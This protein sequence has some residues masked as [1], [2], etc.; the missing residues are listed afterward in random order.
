MALYLEYSTRI[1]EVYLKYI[2]PED[3]HVYSIDEVFMDVTNYLQTYKLTPHDLAM[4]I[5]L[6]VLDTTGITATAGI[7]TNL[8]LCKVAMDIV[9]KHIP[10]DENGVRIAELDEMAYRR[11][12]WEH[13]P[14]TDFWR[15]G[16]GYAKKLEEH[17]MFTM[18]DIARCSIGGEYDYHNEDLLYK[19]FGVNAEL[20]IDHAWGYEPCTMEY[21][22]AYKPESNSIGSG[23]V[24]HEAYTY[25]KA[26]IV[27]KEMLDSLV[28]DLLEKRLVTNQIVMTVGYDIESLTN[29]AIR[30][31]YDGPV[32]TDHYGRAVP[33]HAHGTGNMYKH[34]SSLR[35]ITE[36]GMDLYDRIINPDLLVR[37]VTIAANNVISEGAAKKIVI[38]EQIDLFTD[39]N[40]MLKDEAAENAEQEKEKNLQQTILSLKKKYG[41]NAVLKGMNFKEGA[42]MIDRNGQIGGHKA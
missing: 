28:M 23:Q 1:Y 18:G 38:N 37:R 34:T 41:K 40:K 9:A 17:G 20:L 31:K 19:L 29:P 35:Q 12:L 16:K 26:R 7:G 3:I 4:K 14:L 27:V 39:V 2:A 5:I 25:D 6:D 42:T 30:N 10:P 21:I 36:C 11:K 8:Y 32:T 24:L 33:K 22:K 13:T 15:V